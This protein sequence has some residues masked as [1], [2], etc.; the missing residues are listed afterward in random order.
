M[1]CFMKKVVIL[2]IS[3]LVLISYNNVFA[4][5][6]VISLNKYKEEKLNTIIKSYDDKESIDG[7]ITG[8]VFLKE[9]IDQ[10]N[11]EYNCRLLVYQKYCNHSHHILQNNLSAD[12]LT[13]LKHLQ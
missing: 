13:D 11:N 1:R 10:D 9:I 6:T 4:K 3:L 2:F 12:S 8:G 5:D 7:F